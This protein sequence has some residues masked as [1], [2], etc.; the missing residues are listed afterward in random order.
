MKVAAVVLAAGKSERMGRN[1]L[2]MKVANH[3]I[4]DWIL[5]SLD[6][7]IIDE[8][9]VVLGHKPEEVRPIVEARDAKIIL[10]PNYEKGMVSSF[11]EGLQHTAADA[12]FLVLGDQLGL[13]AELLNRM[14]KAMKLDPRVLIVS[15]IYNNQ[16]GHPVLFSRVLFSEILGLSPDETLQDIV[17]RHKKAHKLIESNVWCVL[18]IDT[19][20]DFEKAK[21]FFET[22]RTKVF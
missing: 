11:K 15:P 19:P 5:L 1:K 22:N 13:E 16:K 10:N 4:I 12:V 2:L 14:I 8:V 3:P 21:R 20:E 9:I 18:D 17:L 7:S 6:D